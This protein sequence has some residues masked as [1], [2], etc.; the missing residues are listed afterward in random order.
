M[1]YDNALLGRLYLEAYQVT[2]NPRYHEIVRETLQFV[3]REMMDPDGGFYSALDADSEGA[4]GK[5]YVWTPSQV[6][7]VLGSN[8]ATIFKEYFDITTTGNF[9]G[10]NIL[11]PRMH[12]KDLAKSAGMSLEK[13]KQQL[14][15]GRQRLLKVREKR[16]R[17]DLDNK[18]LAAWNGMM[19]T[20]FAE[21][22]F[23]L[24]DKEFLNTALNNAEFLAS[25]MMIDGRLL[26]SWRN[27]K[28]HLNAYLEDYALV[29]EGFLSVYQASG[30]IRWLKLADQLMNTQFALFWDPERGNFY[31]T[32]TDHE[33][34]LLRQKEHL[35][36]AIPSGNSL[37]S[38]NL[39]RLSVLCGKE[40]Y[41]K[42]AEG[43]LTQ[44]AAVL[45]QHPTAFGCWLQS[46]DFFLGPVQEIALLAEQGETDLLQPVRK[47]FLP[48]KV[49]AR[50]KKV[51]EP[52]AK[53]IPLLNNKTTHRGQ[54]TLYVCQNYAC[55]APATDVVAVEKALEIRSTD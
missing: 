34:L 45:P 29:T 26:R 14:D 27:G 19:L 17:P 52:L 10:T 48:N 37:S 41:R 55:Q 54:P 24:D 16:V 53:L 28:A 25:K 4:E 40:E 21:A 39:L 32:S 13:L 50:A 47:H 46:L 2:G 42:Q 3:Q 43:M 11:H 35:D 49:V 12:L 20:A 44:V 1:L 51:D 15:W 38:L 18:C 8:D 23:V 36:N 5:H 31:F 9:E 6:E 7:D 30:Q 33:T 22:A